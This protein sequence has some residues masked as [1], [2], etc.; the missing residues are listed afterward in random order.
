MLQEGF[1]QTY[2]V[3][4]GDNIASIA[5]KFNVNVIDLVRENNLENIY[6]LAPGMEL[7]I[8][9]TSNQEVF[10]YYV[11]QKGD[12]LYQ[13]GKRY[14]I[15]AEMLAEMNGLELDEY[16]YPEQKLLVPKE[17]FKPYIT[18]EEDTLKSIADEFGLPRE[19]IL[20]YN[21]KIYLLP[22]QLIVYRKQ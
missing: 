10:D 21:D 22:G 17:G 2:I 8:P 4:P 14:G 20:L 7:I 19:E 9:N 13:I 1:M 16:I 11:V 15:S 3:E 5:K 12:N 18:K 6:Y